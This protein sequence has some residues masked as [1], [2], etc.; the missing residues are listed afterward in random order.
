MDF[1]E[2]GC[3]GVKGGGVRFASRIS[4]TYDGHTHVYQYTDS[5]RVNAAKMVKVHVEEG[6]LHPYAGLMILKMMREIK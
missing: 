3:E 6:Q 2:A 1:D 5:E 4:A